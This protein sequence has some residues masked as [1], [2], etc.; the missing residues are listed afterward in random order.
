MSQEDVV[1]HYSDP[2]VRAEIAVFTRSRW[3]GVHC[4]SKNRLG[5]PILLRYFR[6]GRPLRIR[7]QEDVEGLLKA[8][9]GLGPRTFY[10]TVNLYAKL[11]AADDVADLGNIV[12]CTPTWDV[13]NVPE[14]WKG[15]IAA[16]K[17]VV[18]FLESEGLR[19]SVYVKWS[20]RGCHVHIHERAF[21]NEIRERFPPLDIGYAVV[22]YVNMKLERRFSEI[23]GSI[24]G[25]PLRVD[26]E[27]D[28]QRLFTCPLS[29]HKELD[30]VCVC[31][32]LNDLDNFTPEWAAVGAYR[33]FEGWNRWEEGEGDALAERACTVVGSC[34]SRPSHRGRRNPPLDEQIGRWVKKE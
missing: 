5:R 28:V 26:N 3:V 16:V 15:T 4:I 7:G 6:G 30:R 19:H 9:R 33:H 8:F 17:E 24:P 20:G 13:D 18:S 1:N 29:L 25:S 31:I 22:G 11:E 10:G 14:A 2:K 23:S 21:S 34:P 32:D 12:G 27:M